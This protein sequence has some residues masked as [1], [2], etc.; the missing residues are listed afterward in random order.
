VAKPHEV[1]LN[2]IRPALF[3]VLFGTSSLFAA[4][5]QIDP[6]RSSLRI[7]VGKTGLLSAAGHEHIVMA[8]IAE[9]SIDDGQPSH[10]SFRVEAAR[11]AVMPEEHQI[12]VQHSMQE[13]ILESSRFPEISFT[14]EIIQPIGENAWNVSGNLQLHGQTRVIHLSVHKEDGRYIGATTIKQTDYSIQP[15]SALGGAVKVNNELK[16]DFVIDTK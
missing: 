8:P 9:G 2:S 12:E 16:I 5:K 7:H 13:S 10:I 15:I 3:V 1:P 11:L 6:D 4:Q 14:S